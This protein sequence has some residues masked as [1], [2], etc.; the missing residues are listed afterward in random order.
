MTVMTG[1]PRVDVADALARASALSGFYATLP[2]DAPGLVPLDALLRPDSLADLLAG[3]DTACG[4]CRTRPAR[5]AA[6][7]MLASEFFSVLAAGPP[8]SS[9]P[10]AAPCSWLPAASRSAATGRGASTRS[11]A[12]ARCSCSPTTPRP[13]SRA[14]RPPVR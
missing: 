14:P 13:A 2:A 5:T 3:A 9:S 11:P 10:T 7:I 6:A 4:G 12:P 8:A 1:T